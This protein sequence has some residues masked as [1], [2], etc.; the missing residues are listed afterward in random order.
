VTRPR[1]NSEERGGS[2][3]FLLQTPPSPRFPTTR[4][5][6][7]KV[8]LA[9]WIWQHIKGLAFETALDAFG[10]TGCIAHLLKRHGKEV[11]HN[12][13]LRSN[14]LIGL[15]LIENDSIRLS[16]DDVEFLLSPHQGI[17]YPDF[18]QRTFPSIY[19]T[20]DE[21]AWLDMVATNIRHL[22]DPCKQALAYFALFEAC[23]VKRPFNLFH[24]KNL[25]LRAADVP[26]TFGNKATWDTPFPAHFRKFVA[27]GNRAVFA[28]GRRNRATNADAMEI[29]G[30]YDL[31][32]VDTP[33]ISTDGIGV[34]YLAFYHF[35]EGLADYEHW[36]EHIDFGTKHRAFQKQP[37]EWCDRNRVHHAFD[38]LFERFRD[39]ILVVS[40]RA[41]G[42][43]SIPELVSLLRRHKQ[44]V[45]VTQT[46]NYRYVLSK[47]RSAEVLLVAQ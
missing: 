26:R 4:Y 15:A 45:N 17:A 6:G 11:T 22:D 9:P 2:Q 19:F 24:R 40:Y 31:V 33:Y 10:G 46:L 43:P 25:Y 18:I 41:D 30:P 42:I 39:S 20:D 3:L 34:D 36:A 35:L 47:R 1:T 16:E 44:R 38:R 7:S 29:A 23:L 27:A 21:N 28:N 8:K 37:C 13:L 12:D 5:Q 14:H 32:Y